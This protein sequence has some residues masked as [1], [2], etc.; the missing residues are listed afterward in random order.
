LPITEAGAG[1]V[2]EPVGITLSTVHY[3]PEG[4]KFLKN[5]PEGS[6]FGL[7]PTGAVVSAK[8]FPPKG[9]EIKSVSGV[10]VKAAKDDKGRAI[11]GVS[12]VADDQ[13]GYGEAMTYNSNDSEKSGSARIELR[14]GLPAPDA[15]AI[16]ELQGEAVALTVG[17]W[18][19]MVVTN[20]QADAKKEI[21]LG[22]V[23]P[24]AKLTIKKIAGRKPQKTVEAALEG[25]KEVT[26]IDV[27]VKLSSHRGGQSNMNDRRN[28]TSGDKTT[29]NI[30]IEA[31]EFE[32]GG[33]AE[34][35]PL[36]LLVRYPQDVRRE[37]VQFKLT[38]LDLF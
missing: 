25:P 20:V 28:K 33:E 24:G 16:D 2:A 21:D 9:R 26:Q 1:F 27:K 8:L 10:R 13:E 14:M 31:Y 32:M 3:F 23:L 22:E 37:R 29:R 6:M 5:Q 19:E 18:K 30:T 7:N 15:K 17:G 11:P 12:E 35:G 4:D 36:T 34:S 38:A